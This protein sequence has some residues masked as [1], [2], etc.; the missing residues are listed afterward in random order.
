[1]AYTIMPPHPLRR[2]QAVTPH[3]V[4][5]YDP[6]LVL[7]R[8]GGAGDLNAVNLEGTTVA[9]TGVTAGEY[10]PGPFLQILA[11]ST[12]TAVVGWKNE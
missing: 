12:V 5:S 3:A 9:I 10:V 4:T 11:T 7:V 8:C 1:M 2:F 6:P